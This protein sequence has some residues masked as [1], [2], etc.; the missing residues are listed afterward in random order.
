MNS[1]P[2]QTKAVLRLFSPCSSDCL[3][4]SEEKYTK[5]GMDCVT[6]LIVSSEVSP[7]IVG[8]SLR[9]QRVR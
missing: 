9:K 2:A 5:F 8:G 1:V 6:L 4:V 7:G 3:Q